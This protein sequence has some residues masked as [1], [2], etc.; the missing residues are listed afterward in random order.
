MGFAMHYE[1][2]DAAL[3]LRAR[4]VMEMPE[5]TCWHT[6]SSIRSPQMD[7]PQ[8]NAPQIAQITQTVD[9]ADDGYGDDR[10]RTT[11]YADDQAAQTLGNADARASRSAIRHS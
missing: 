5:L 2:I 8:I 9:Y 11:G 7:A 6:S 10:S 1:A 4:Q 3:A